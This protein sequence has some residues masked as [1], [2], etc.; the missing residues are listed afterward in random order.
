MEDYNELQSQVALVS[1]SDMKLA[2]EENIDGIECYK[3]AGTPVSAIEKTIL[4]VQLF[5]IISRI[6]DQFAGRL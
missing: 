4:G 5:C 6:S 3:L 1:Y 2:G